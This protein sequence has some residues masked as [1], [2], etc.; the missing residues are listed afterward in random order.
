MIPGRRA[1]FL[2]FL[3][4]LAAL[5]APAAPAQAGSWLDDARYAR[6]GT[7]PPP[8]PAKR[9]PVPFTEPLIVDSHAYAREHGFE[10]MHL[11]PLPFPTSRGDEFNYVP[12]A[13][14]YIPPTPGTSDAGHGR[15]S[16]A[17]AAVILHPNYSLYGN[18]GRR[19]GRRPLT[20]EPTGSLL[21]GAT[22][23]VLRFES[24]GRR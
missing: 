22:P 4:A 19:F 23:R 17:P 12:K 15:K 3:A 14:I 8:P 13:R 6:Y 10:V 11:N 2:P 18:Y 9:P 1:L 16:I 7:I 5:L 21:R 20:L 24:R